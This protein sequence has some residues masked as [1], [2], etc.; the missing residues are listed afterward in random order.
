[1]ATIIAGKVFKT[2]LLNIAKKK[3]RMEEKTKG[4]TTAC[5]T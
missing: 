1:V 5:S 3:G 2:A 4:D